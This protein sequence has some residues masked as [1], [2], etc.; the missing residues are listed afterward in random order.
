ML[1][2]QFCDLI[3]SITIY[4]ESK[5]PTPVD[6]IN[7]LLYIKYQVWQTIIKY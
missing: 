5:L 1:Q 3:P 6:F 7:K 4:R 2:K